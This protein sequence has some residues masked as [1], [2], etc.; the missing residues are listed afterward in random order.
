M[1]YQSSY[2]HDAMCHF[3]E[4]RDEWTETVDDEAEKEDSH[5]ALEAERDVDVEL[6]TDGGD[7][8]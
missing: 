2:T 3:R 7:D 8:D 6:L 5:P 4:T 1:W